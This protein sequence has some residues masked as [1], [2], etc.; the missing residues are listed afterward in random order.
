LYNGVGS[1]IWMIKDCIWCWTLLSVISWSN[2]LFGVER[3]F[4]LFRGQIFYLVLNAT[5]SYI[6]VEETTDLTQ[7]HWQTYFK[8]EVSRRTLFDLMHILSWKPIMPIIQRRVWK[9]QRGNQNQRTTAYTYNKGKHIK[10]QSMSPT[11]TKDFTLK[12]RVWAPQGQHIKV[13]S[14][15]PTGTKDFT[16]KYRV[17]AP[18][19]QMTSH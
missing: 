3:Y 14:M 1:F 17:W 2:I 9:Y 16:L 8:D 4:P 19:G 7:S 5:F 6:V 10:V 15:S 18:H 13:Q 11:G 12:Y